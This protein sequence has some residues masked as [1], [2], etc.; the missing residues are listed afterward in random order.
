MS[1]QF[2]PYQREGIVRAYHAMQDPSNRGGFYL[3]WK[4]G[5]GKSL[6][7]IALH[8]KLLSERTAIVCPVVAQGVWR[9]EFEKWLPGLVISDIDSMDSSTQVVITTYDKLK[10]PKAGNALAQRRTGAGRLHKLQAWEPELLI[11]DEAQYIKSPSAARTRAM[12]KLAAAAQWKLL[13][14]GT[15][16]HSP[17]DWWSQFRVVAPHEPVFRQT[18]SEFK[19]STVVLMQ[20]PNGAYP[21]R[22]RNGALVVKVDGHKRVVDA[23]APY[24]HAVPKSVLNLPEPIVTEVPITLSA[25][26]RKAYT[27]METMLR[28]ELVDGKGE[29]TEANA[30][31]V[32]TK[33]LR[34]T[35]IAA[36]HVTSED[37]ESI[38]V[39]RSKLDAALELLAEREDEKVVVACRFKRD[40]LDL[41]SELEKAGRPYRIIAGNVTGAKRTQAEDWFQTEQHNGVMIIQYQAGGVAITLTAATTLIMFTLTPSVIQWEQTTSRV[42][43]IGTTTNVQVLYLIA[44][45]TQDEIMLAAL[46]RGASVVDM[47]RLLMR[48]LNRQDGLAA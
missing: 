10:D 11:L 43:R 23:M 12:W 7:A 18:Y 22:G 2:H 13:L 28:T 1:V 35:Q 21:V 33:I 32:L 48:Y 3:Q 37:G 47:C 36:G 31:I 41:A 39:G 29:I 6:G 42:H 38:H 25:A 20:G 27:Q 14:S 5:M 9:R 45:Q 16:A 19:Q 4:P 15:P 40:I 17:L 44:Q 8:R 26:E 30:T 24:V 34:L 46:Q